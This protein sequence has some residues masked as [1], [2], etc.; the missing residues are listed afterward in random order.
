MRVK[1]SKPG[2]EELL[3]VVR[4]VRNRWRLKIALRGFGIVLA[5]GLVILMMSTYAMDRFR[6]DEL[7]VNLIRIV[8][9]G[10]MI[11]LIVRYLV[12][13]LA[14]RVPDRRVALYL[15]ENE[16]T[17]DGHVLTGIEYGNE[18]NRVGQTETSPALVKRLV[19]R[20]VQKCA[21]VDDGRGVERKTILT[22]SGMT[23]GRTST[24]P[25]ADASWSCLTPPG[26]PWFPW[27]P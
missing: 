25:S 14:K 10:T 21:S 9:Y 8:S 7:A 24:G 11:L 12:V 6:F 20:A 5:G 19:Q 27:E 22:S 3:R 17:L 26:S 1:F 16:P 2:H 4:S 23:A 18:G 13:P 15:E